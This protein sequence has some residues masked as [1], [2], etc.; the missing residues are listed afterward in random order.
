MISLA[1]FPFPPARFSIPN[2]HQH[3]RPALHPL[4]ILLGVLA[5]DVAV[6]GLGVELER[7]VVA[8]CG[9]GGRGFERGM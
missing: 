2:P 9:G 4:I 6:G 1:T 8:G 7:G 5:A 3:P